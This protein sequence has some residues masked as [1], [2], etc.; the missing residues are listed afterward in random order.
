[1]S[2]TNRL[3]SHDAGFHYSNSN[4]IHINNTP[5]S[6]LVLS[7]SVTLLRFVIY[8]GSINSK[9]PHHHP[10]FYCSLL[11]LL[12]TLSSSLQSPWIEAQY[13]MGK[14]FDSI[15]PNIIDFIQRQHL[16]WVATAP[17][18]P[19]GTISCSPKGAL[20]TFH[21]VNANRVWYEDLSGTG[22]SHPRFVRR[23]CL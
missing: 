13:G 7:T 18:S 23:L 5:S 1:M 2:C 8:K 11:A 19:D 15:P 10:S 12:L 14:F 17:L 16:F 9:Y 20:G 4:N 3:Q 22:E 21:V 6:W